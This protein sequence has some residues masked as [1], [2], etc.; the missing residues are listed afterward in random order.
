[1]RTIKIASFPS[2]LLLRMSI[3]ARRGSKIT[4]KKITR[5][6]ISS[7]NPIDHI[8]V[9]ISEFDYKYFSCFLISR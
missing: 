8:V 1:M 5:I 4:I 7:V 9:S 3:I 6:K 2:N